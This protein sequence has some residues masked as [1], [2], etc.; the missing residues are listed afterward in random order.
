MKN[1]T[2]TILEQMLDNKILINIDILRFG[3]YIN[4]LKKKQKKIL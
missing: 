1:K 2:K 4:N 3:I